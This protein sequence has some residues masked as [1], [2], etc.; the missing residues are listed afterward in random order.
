MNALILVDVQQGFL[1]GPTAGVMT[2]KLHQLV[3]ERGLFDRIVA[4]RYGNSPDSNLSR[5]K[6]WRSLQTGAE[7]AIPAD[8]LARVD[9]VVDKSTYSGC[10]P[11]LWEDLVRHNGG[12]P[13]EQVFLAGVDIGCCV[14]ETA[15]DFFEA[16]VRP[17]VLTAYCWAAGGPAYYDAAILCLHNLIG[18]RH[19]IHADPIRTRGQLERLTRW[20]KPPYG[21][22][23]RGSAFRL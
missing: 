1:H 7:R 13:P 15:A 16:G 8:I 11:V 12:N 14:M 4:T 5:L 2:E 17:Y 21:P 19:L 18:R 22:D 9:R 10:T 3:G 20:A 6:N 23:R